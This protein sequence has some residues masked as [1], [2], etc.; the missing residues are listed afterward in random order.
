LIASL[1]ASERER[2]LESLTENERKELLYAW[3][4]WA[5]PVQLPP[6]GDWR[7]WLYLGGRGAGKTRS[8]AEY[9]R[10]QVESGQ[11]RRPGL[12]APTASDARDVMVEG[13]S[14]FLHI[15]P[16]DNMP[17]YEP[18]KRRLTWPNGA[19][20]TLYSADE[21]KRLRG[22]QHDLIWADEVAHWRYPETWDMA[23][24]GLRIGADPR[25]IVTTTPKPVPL[26]KELKRDPNTVTTRSTTYENLPNLAP[27]FADEIIGRY[28]GT[29]LGRQELL[30]EILDDNPDAL[31]SRSDIEESR[32]IKAP[33]LVRI[34][35]GVDPQARNEPTSAETG[36]VVAGRDAHGHGYILD[37]L[38]IKATPEKW[39]QR[40]VTGYYRHNADRIIGEINNG[41]DMVEF[42][43]R[44][45]DRNISYKGVHASRGKQ[46][47]AE[48]ISSLYEQG[49][50]HH[51][52]MFPELEDQLCEWV[53][54]DK[55]PDRLDALVWAL[56]ELMFKG[57]KLEFLK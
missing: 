9:V 8:G 49:K 13:D 25:A 23:L 38:S 48:P 35:V 14:G 1:P 18:S 42:T 4:F 53:P 43:I 34:V 33:D 5:R 32:V 22:P 50:V 15:C 19:R 56:T 10:E 30:A 29:R 7:V 12:I 24:L 26:I 11:V 54:G 27:A 3:W 6:E 36:I 44:T 37:D 52:G 16:P 39:A 28:E 45:V 21:P 51:V 2:F 20:A 41:G 40:A 17:E 31:W 46:I 57:G 47:R 55:S